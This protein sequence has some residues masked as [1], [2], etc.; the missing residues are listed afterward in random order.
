MPHSQADR[1]CLMHWCM[2]FFNTTAD[3]SPTQRAGLDAHACMLRYCASKIGS[4]SLAV[5]SSRDGEPLAGSPFQFDVTPGQLSP[6][7]CTA[8]LAAPTLV[9]GQ[10]AAIV[11]DAKDMHGNQVGGTVDMSM[12]IS[13]FS[14]YHPQIA[15]LLV[16]ICKRN[17][18]STL[19]L[20]AACS[21]CPGAWLNS[22]PYRAGQPR[23]FFTPA[24]CTA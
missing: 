6:C 2:H 23:S 1:K 15:V 18:N 16:F 8:E 9:A 14:P 11:I 17:Q 21:Y 20:D 13:S 12:S 5:T 3:I 4:Y 24:Q 7:H 22:M 19:Y 10:K